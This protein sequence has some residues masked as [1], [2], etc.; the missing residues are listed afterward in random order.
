MTTIAEKIFNLWDEHHTEWQAI[1]EEGV[2]ITFTD[3]SVLAIDL[4]GKIVH[5][6]EHRES[7]LAPVQPCDGPEGGERCATCDGDQCLP[8]DEI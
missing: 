8:D 4:D 5:W 6:D 7:V 1:D 2:R 3:A